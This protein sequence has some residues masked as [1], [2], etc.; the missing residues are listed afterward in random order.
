MQ[1]SLL[2]YYSYL[3]PTKHQI[4]ALQNALLL[5]IL[6]DIWYKGRYYMIRW[7]RIDKIE[8]DGTNLYHR[9]CFWGLQILL[10]RKFKE[11]VFMNLHFSSVCNPCHDRISDNFQWK[12]LV[13]VRKIHK[14]CKICS[15]QK[16][17]LRYCVNSWQYSYVCLYVYIIQSLTLKF[18]VPKLK[19]IVVKFG[20]LKHSLLPQLQGD[21][22]DHFLSLSQK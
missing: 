17:A 2:L 15:P 22:N 6:T 4:F 18:G 5:L 19:L 3:Q 11:T 8:I 9:A 13:E 12:N 1:K 7:K 16:V 20:C 14:I 10:K 21:V